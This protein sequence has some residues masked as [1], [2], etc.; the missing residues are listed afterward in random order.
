MSNILIEPG[1]STFA[2]MVASI[3]DGYYLV[4]AKG[5]QTAG[6]QFSFGAMWGF[7]IRGG[8]LGRMVR[9]V[10]MSGELFSTLRGI[11]RVGDDLHFA[12]S[13]GYGKGGGGPI[14]M[15]RKSGKGAPHIKIDRVT[16]GGTR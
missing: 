2:E 15:N 4:G 12:Q 14:Q 8:R 5:G 16:L 3:D 13:G 9:D 7:R 10:N 1:S 6:D 11:S